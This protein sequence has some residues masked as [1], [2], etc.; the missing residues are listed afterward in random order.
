MPAHDRHGAASATALRDVAALTHGD[1]LCV[2]YE[3]L[4]DLLPFV[5]AFVGEGLRRGERCVYCV[6]DHADH[7]ILPTLAGSGI[8]VDRAIGRGALVCLPADG[9]RGPGEFDPA[10]MLE[11]LDTA[12][13]RARADGFTG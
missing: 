8:D 2:V 12:V 4:A 13:A 7:D 6:D 5:S 1:H 10:S 3:T 9:Y 11:H